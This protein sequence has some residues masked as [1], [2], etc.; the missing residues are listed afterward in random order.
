Q[1]PFRWRNFENHVVEIVSGT[2]QPKPTTSGLP[3]SI[4]IDQDRDYF[5]LRVS[6]N[7]AV[8]FA[9]TT[10]HGDHVGPIREIHVEFLFE[11]SPKLIASH[12]LNELCK[13][14]SVTDFTQSKAAGPVNS[15]IIIMYR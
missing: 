7:F 14:G 5:R 12:L 15:G 2:E 10:A 13:C 8:F 3:P 1:R 11:G 6:V 4:H 9:A